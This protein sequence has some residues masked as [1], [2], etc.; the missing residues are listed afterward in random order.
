MLL[1]LTAALM[2][3]VQF[4]ELAEAPTGPFVVSARIP[5]QGAPEG[6]MSGS[7]KVSGEQFACLTY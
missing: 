3:Q 5:F 4:M 6:A 7:G 1:I 2:L